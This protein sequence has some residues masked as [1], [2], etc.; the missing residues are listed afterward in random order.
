MA[1]TRHNLERSVHGFVY[2]VTK[3]AS[4]D[5]EIGFYDKDN[6]SADTYSTKDGKL[7]KDMA[8]TLAE[9]LGHNTWA[10]IELDA[11]GVAKSVLLEEYDFGRDIYR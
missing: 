3:H 5:I 1:I 4:G 9:S 2:H 6:D 7:T 8:Q 10:K 11:K